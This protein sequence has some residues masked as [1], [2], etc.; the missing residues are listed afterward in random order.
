MALMTTHYTTYT[1]KMAIV[2]DQ[3]L[4][5]VTSPHIGESD[6]TE[7]MVTTRSPFCGYNTAQCVELRDEDLV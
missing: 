6:V 5:D 3:R 1:H 2:R 7:S 4:C